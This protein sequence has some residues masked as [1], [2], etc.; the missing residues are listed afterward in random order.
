MLDCCEAVQRVRRQNSASMHA[1]LRQISN[2]I[3]PAFGYF[4]TPP[5]NLAAAQPLT[6]SSAVP[7]P[8]GSYD[9]M[10][11]YGST[12]YYCHNQTGTLS[13][14]FLIQASAPPA[15]HAAMHAAA[16]C[17]VTVLMFF[18]ALQALTV[19]TQSGPATTTYGDPTFAVIVNVT[20]PAAALQQPFSD[21]GAVQ[22]G[23]VSLTLASNDSAVPGTATVVDSGPGYVTWQFSASQPF[24][25]GSNTVAAS[26]SPDA[27]Y[28]IGSTSAGYTFTVIPVRFSILSITAPVATTR[29]HTS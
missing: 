9:A 8:A 4:D 21:P 6:P 22:V 16:C 10:L 5:L 27:D 13:G 29:L 2:T 12:Q 25:L 20:Y 3:S 7:L 18:Y 24:P 17:G 23:E 14:A 19:T 1:G 15:V 28:L 11:S 26:Y